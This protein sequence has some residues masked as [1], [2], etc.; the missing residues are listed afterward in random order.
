MLESEP[1]ML[2]IIVAP[3]ED[4]IE[5]RLRETL[6]LERVLVIACPGYDDPTGVV[7]R[8]GVTIMDDLLL[9]LVIIVLRKRVSLVD[10]IPVCVNEVIEL[11]IGFSVVGEVMKDPPSVGSSLDEEADDVFGLI[12]SVL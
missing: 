10:D 9:L 6:K 11:A 4:E 2:P 8:K 7:P 12:T 5:E 1:R 3:A